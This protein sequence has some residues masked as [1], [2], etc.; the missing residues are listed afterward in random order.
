[1]KYGVREICNVVMRAKGTMT[2]GTKTFYKNE[3]VLYFDTLKTSSL[4][5]SSSTVYAQGGR[6][7]ARLM[8]WDGDK[9]TTFTMEDALISPEGLMILAGAD[10][11]SAGVQ[12]DGSTKTI[13]QHINTIVPVV[14][15]LSK[16]A[17]GAKTT[18]SGLTVKL[19]IARDDATPYYA[20]GEKDMIYVMAMKDG[21][22]FS[23]PFI[24]TYADGSITVDTIQKDNR[25]YESDPLKDDG[26]TINQKGLD[27]L[28]AADSFMIDYYTAKE[29]SSVKEIQITAD[30]FG[31]AFY[32]EAD[33]LFRNEKGIDVPAE[34]VIPNCRVQSNFNFSMS[35]SGDPSTFTFAMDCFP[36][37]TRWDPTKK[38]LAAI[39]IIPKAGT[40]ESYRKVTDAD[41]ITEVPVG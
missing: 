15:D 25:G 13:M 3:P 30:S 1:M 8:S 35:G 19:D 4:E 39:Q 38:V 10:L 16:V 23:E 17:R 31:S 34:F 32:L 33:T 9:T 29:D 2:L 24:G 12:K 18:T 20:A 7:N 28:K 5:G 21:E 11:I 37:Y 27:Q 40:E 14:A 36:D 6:G 26:Y 41:D 22:I